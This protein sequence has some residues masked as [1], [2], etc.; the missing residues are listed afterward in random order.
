MVVTSPFVYFYG[1]DSTFF[2][3]IHITCFDYEKQDNEMTLLVIETGN[4]DTS[5]A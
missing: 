5:A 4:R 1:L 3:L 2:V